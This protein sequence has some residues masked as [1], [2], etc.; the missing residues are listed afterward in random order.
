MGRDLRIAEITFLLMSR[1]PSDYELNALCVMEQAITNERTL[2]VAGQRDRGWTWSVID[3]GCIF[4]ATL[5]E[6]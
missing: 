1:V 5:P 4:N 6:V 3:P 2:D